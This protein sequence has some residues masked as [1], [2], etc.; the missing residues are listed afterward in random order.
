MLRS[1][2]AIAIAFAA[3]VYAAVISVIVTH[4]VQIDADGGLAAIDDPSGSMAW[5]SQTGAFELPVLAFWVVFAGRLVLSWRRPSLDRRQ[6]LKWLMSGSAIAV[7]C[8]VI[9][10]VVP[11]L[12]S[13]ATPVGVGVVLPAGLGVAILKYRLY[14][15]DRII[16]RTLAYAIVTGLLVGLYAGLVLLATR[17]LSFHTPVAVAASTLAAALFNPLRRR[18]QLAVDRRFNRARYDADQTVAAFAARLKDAVELRRAGRPGQRGAR[19]L[20]PARILVWMN[21]GSEAGHFTVVQDAIGAVGSPRALT[22][23][24]GGAGDRSGPRTNR[25]SCAFAHSVAH[26]QKYRECRLEQACRNKVLSC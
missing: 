18:I 20:E 15:I 10:N 14:A 19:A 17:V 12:D 22:D 21:N 3:A 4:G 24:L 11:A 1:Y 25:I 2:L 26:L 13:V 5:V 8:V 9:G 23:C 16:S 6:Q 7:A